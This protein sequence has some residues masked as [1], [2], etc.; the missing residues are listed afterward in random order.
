[1][2][3]FAVL[4]LPALA[5]AAI[6]PEAIGPFHRVSTSQPTIAARDLWDEYGLRDYESGAYENGAAKMKVTAYRLQDSTGA[7][8]AFDWLRPAAAKVSRIAAYAAET[9]AELMLVRGNYLLNFEGY[10]PTAAELDELAGKLTNVDATAFPSLPG[11]LPDQDLIPNSERYI[12]GPVGLARFVGGIP[13][14]V[15]AFRYSAEAVLGVFHSPKGDITLAIFD[16]PTP[17][18]A[19]DRLADFQNIPGALAKRAGPLVAAIVKPADPD[20]AERILAQVQYRADITMQEH[21]ATK[22][23]NIGNLVI[24]A[25][26]LTGILLVFCVVAG[27]AVGGFRILKR[28]GKENA[29]VDSMIQLHLE[30][31]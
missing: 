14:S 27:F 2:K 1:M 8:A 7:M 18:I 30:R 13:P 5:G 25:F 28:R 29:D 20:M 19:R 3:F 6:L 22:R 21:I 12:Q 26:I 23:D 24:N 31:R 15:A 17:Q 10:K 9:P 4:L 16:Y 11:Y